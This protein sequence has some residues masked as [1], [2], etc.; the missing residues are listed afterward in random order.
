MTAITL[1]ASRIHL[2]EALMVP[3]PAMRSP[4]APC[5][6][7]SFESY[8]GKAPPTRIDLEPDSFA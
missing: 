1:V 6:I 3:T 5:R 4:A 8:L 7:R 2:L